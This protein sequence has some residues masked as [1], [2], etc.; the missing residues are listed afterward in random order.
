MI[1]GWKII[2]KKDWT[3]S[4]H[5]NQEYTFGEKT[6]LIG[7]RRKGP[8]DLGYKRMKKCLIR[9]FKWLFRWFASG[10]WVKL[11]QYL[12]VKTNSF[13]VMRMWLFLVKTTN[14]LFYSKKTRNQAL[15][16]L[17]LVTAIYQW[18]YLAENAEYVI[19]V[20]DY[21]FYIRSFDGD[22]FEIKSINYSLFH[23][24]ASFAGLIF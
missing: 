7:R 22:N 1:C 18:K 10:Y 11:A 24:L 5:D 20:T 8:G 15:L 2:S 19:W 3:F 9:F 4:F 16:T 17:F 23:D 14:G 6:F 12:S 21:V 13:L